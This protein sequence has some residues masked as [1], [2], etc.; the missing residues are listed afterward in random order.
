MN[1][2]PDVA[3]KLG[4]DYE[5]LSALNPRLVYC[6]LTAFG[7]EG[8]DAHR[9][10]YDMILQGRSGL[11]A[12]EG[13]IAGDLPDAYLGQPIDRHHL[14]HDPGMVRMWSFI[15]PGAHRARPKSRDQ[16]AGRFHGAAWQAA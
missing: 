2:R 13:K 10:A 6:E 8:P 3:V 5:T 4:I 15:C 9:P 16:H 1:Y 14:R 7:R 12:A 11:L